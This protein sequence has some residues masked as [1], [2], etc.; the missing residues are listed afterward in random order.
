M[1]FN[2]R[3]TDDEIE[4]LFAEI[5]DEFPSDVSYDG[6]EECIPLQCDYDISDS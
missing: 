6:E 2:K 4:N 5:S 1:Q 3:L